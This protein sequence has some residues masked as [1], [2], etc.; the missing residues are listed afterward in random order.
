MVEDRT[1]DYTIFVD[2][3]ENT[4]QLS[5]GSVLAITAAWDIDDDATTAVTSDDPDPY[6]EINNGVIDITTTGTPYET[7][8]ASLSPRHRGQILA[9]RQ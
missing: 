3:S 6:V 7:A 2:F 1:F 5:T 4:A 8:T 9:D